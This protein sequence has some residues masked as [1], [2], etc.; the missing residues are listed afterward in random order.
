MKLTDRRLIDEHIEWCRRHRFEV[1]Q[2]DGSLEYYDGN[3]WYPLIALWTGDKP[4]RAPE[5][6]NESV[7]SFS[8]DPAQ[9]PFRTEILVSDDGTIQW[10][11]FDESE[12]NQ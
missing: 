5:H 9:S 10:E 4:T 8:I 7:F 3:A 2:Q 12:V 1:R 6:A 11:P